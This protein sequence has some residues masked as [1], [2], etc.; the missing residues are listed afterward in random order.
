M[1]L[2]KILMYAEF[3]V[4]TWIVVF[5]IAGYID[6]VAKRSMEGTTKLSILIAIG[7]TGILWS[8]LT[9]VHSALCVAA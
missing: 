3:L 9:L 5:G 1:D 6:A 8:V 4:F 7:A 2:I